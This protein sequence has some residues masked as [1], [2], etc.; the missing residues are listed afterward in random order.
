MQDFHMV[1]PFGGGHME[2]GV[3]KQGCLGACVYLAALPVP[4]IAPGSA[5]TVSKYKYPH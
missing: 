1:A 2:V 5:R 4:Q 3:E